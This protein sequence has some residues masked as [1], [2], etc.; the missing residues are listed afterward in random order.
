[1]LLVLQL[2]KETFS[3][4][5]LSGSDSCQGKGQERRSNDSTALDLTVIMIECQ[6]KATQATRLSYAVPLP[7]PIM[8][9]LLY[10]PGLPTPCR[11]MHDGITIE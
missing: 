2:R 6:I 7:P 5:S 1:M 4:R 8:I 9:M 3:A 11:K 10:K